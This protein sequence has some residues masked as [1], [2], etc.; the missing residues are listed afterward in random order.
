MSLFLPF[1]Q[2]FQA[3]VK[4]FQLY[5]PAHPRTV[6]A[7]EASL[8]A[9]GSLFTGD[10][11]CR[12]AVTAGR[13]YFGKDRQDSKNLHISALLRTMEDRQINGFT[14][15]P[16]V[17]LEELKSLMTLFTMKPAQIQ[18]AGGPAKVLEDRNVQNIRILQ[19]RLEEI[20]D[21]EDLVSLQGA[22]QL[23]GQ[24]A[25]MGGGG[26]E[27]GGAGSRGTGSFSLAGIGE[28]GQGG[29]G[30]N[31]GPGG[32]GE[33]GL[34]APT[35]T[36]HAGLLKGFLSG[37]ARGGMA[38]AD[39]SGLP[40]FLGQLG[41]EAHDPNVGEM[42]FGAMQALPAE[43]QVGLLRGIAGIPAGAV[44]QSL[45]Q[46]TSTFVETS[47]GGAFG[48]GHTSVAPLAQAAEE[49]LPLSGN[50]KRA[51]QQTLDAL[52]QQGMSEAQIQELADIV[53][54][55]SQP[56]EE[57]LQK[58]MEDQKIF[59]M[60]LDKVLAFL[61]EL[62]EGG[63]NQ[64]FLK[65]MKHYA[66]GLHAP[67]V[68]RR[69]QVAEG[70]QRIAGWV[71]IPGIPDSILEPLLGILRIHY[72]REKDPEVH[73]WTSRGV[74]CLLWH[75]VQNGDP[76]RAERE[77]EELTDTV[78]ELSLPAPW[79]AQATAD[80][81]ARLGSTERLTKVVA[82]LYLI[83]RDTAAK[84]VHPFLVMLGGTS[85]RF[86]AQSL[87]EEQDRMKRGRLLEALKAMGTVAVAPLMEALDAP[88]WYVV[89][90]A[91]NV[92]GE[93]GTPDMAGDIGRAA[94]HK[95]TRVVK[96]A[97]GA[98]WKLGGR[99]AE[100]II[101]AHLRHPDPETQMEALFCLG[102]MKAKNSALAIAELTKPPK[103]LQG[104][105]SQK[106]RERAIEILGQL[107]TP[108]ALDLFSELI[109]RKGLFGGATEPFEIRAA[110]ARGLKAFGTA[111][112]MG[113]LRKAVEDEPK[114]AERRALE[115]ILNG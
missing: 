17:T 112:A 70:F 56:F 20:G 63:R 82:L 52:R 13:L 55:D 99:Q 18:D 15:V 43:Q 109:K 68:A 1:A 71:D 4:S 101:T 65:L 54:W 5:G 3:G 23:M 38:T 75:W 24:L 46:A 97:I 85:A 107:G 12:I 48:E 94:L 59:E 28:G 66:T 26:G 29:G 92:L 95:D 33:A 60:P 86:L 103:L 69:A 104:G 41:L 77:W 11:G 93:I 50:P 32:A 67:A 42:I 61:R 6:E 62:L 10:K 30:G 96:A 36:R 47:L 39:L 83:D 34:E 58:L 14:M 35:A 79:K 19:S 37:L 88:E 64:D 31:G 7:L 74:E 84:E 76:R 8:G 106:V 115:A 114:G 49:I 21:D 105:P 87:A 16:G 90:N 81:L 2:S 27:G 73:A 51:L 40:A 78:T 25:A 110:T 44:R 72:G 102:E 91:L 53:T 89:R 22:A 98:L 9:V 108:F 80:L 57:R 100:S 113:I 111:E 45:A